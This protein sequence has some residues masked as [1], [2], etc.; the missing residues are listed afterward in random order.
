[1]EQMAEESLR[2]P[3]NNTQDICLGCQPSQSNRYIQQTLAA[4]TKVAFF[5]NLFEKV[6][7][8]LLSVICRASIILLFKNL[9]GCAKWIIAMI[10]PVQCMLSLDKSAIQSE[11]GLQGNTHLSIIMRTVDS[12]YPWKIRKETHKRETFQ[13]RF[14]FTNCQYLSV[15]FF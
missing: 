9:N 5:I 2:L 12:K 4:H 1:M 3:P 7:Y 6:G 10:I 8:M 11:Q 14:S 15:F 13:I